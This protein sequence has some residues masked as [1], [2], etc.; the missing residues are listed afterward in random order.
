MTTVGIR[1]LKTHLSDYIARAK[2]G[3]VIVVTDRGKQVAQLTP[4]PESP[5]DRALAF[6]RAGHAEWGGGRP[7]KLRP[8]EGLKEGASASDIIIQDRDESVERLLR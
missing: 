1:E 3:E 8:V 2:A 6:V 4:V 5:E 7:P